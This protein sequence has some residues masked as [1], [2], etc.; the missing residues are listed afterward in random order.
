MP[1]QLQT[2]LLMATVKN[3]PCPWLKFLFQNA[4]SNQTDFTENIFSSAQEETVPTKSQKTK[5]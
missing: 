1:T 3:K 5:G 2:P 4:F